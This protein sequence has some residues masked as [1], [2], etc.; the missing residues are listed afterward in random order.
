MCRKNGRPICIV[1]ASI[2]TLVAISSAQ[3]GGVWTPELCMKAKRVS[4]VQVSPDGAR[5]AFVVATAAMEGERSEWLSHIHL[6]RP[7][8]SAGFQLTQGDQS[9][10]SPR[11][12]SDGNWIAFISTRGGKPNLWRIRPDAGEA[13]QLTHEEGGVSGLEWSPDGT[14]IAFL[15]TDPA[16]EEERKAAKEKRDARVVDENIKLARLYVVPVEK[17]AGGGRPV[18][19]LTQGDYSVQG[20]FS[21]SPDGRSIVYSHQPTPVMND[22]PRA[23]ISIVDVAFAAERPFLTTNRAETSPHFSPDGRWIAYA[24]SDDPPSWGFTSRVYV[25]P[26]GG[27]QPKPLAESYD[28]Q[29]QL[30]GWSADGSRVFISETQKTIQR[31]SA[32]PV[33]AGAQIDI[34]PADLMVSGASISASRTHVGFT[35]DTPERAPEPYLSSLGGFA[36]RQ[37]DR[38]QDLTSP[39]IGKTEVIVWK[40]T[41]GKSVE[42]LLTY[43]AGHR[44]GSRVPLLVIVHGGPTGVFT[45]SFIASPGPYPIAVFAS[46]GYSVLRCNVRGS[47]GYGRDFRYANYQDWGGG[48]YRDIMSGV[49]HLI[50]QGLADPDR[51]GIMGWSYGG[52]MTSWVITQTKRFKAAS[53]GAGVTNLMSFS[54]TSDVPAFVPDYFGGE[55]WQVFDRWRSH[56]AMFN[57]GGAAT[58]TLIQH[59]EEDL[60]V[61]VT[62]GYELYNAIKRQNVPVKM[63]VYPR[64]PHGIQ[65]PKLQLDAMKRNLEWFDRWI[66]GN[67]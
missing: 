41:D 60:R 16:T 34:S 30:L 67:K 33:D 54:G 44:Q 6:S 24:A 3:H 7:D 49:D 47:S 31:F 9:C 66:G 4:D 23:D 13:E 27:G 59:G 14:R 40:S 28:S 45:R 35:S 11:W 32:L 8:G 19:K 29:P 10:R 12:S 62:Q 36:P 55:Y 56:S 65:E 48:D 61:P 17:D 15:M 51:L 57:V 63:V 18:R 20:G 58:P 46:R 38:V 42:G 26:A 21:W 5:A 2:L 39:P 22:W 43:P 37:V 52:Y 53:V 1:L 64:Q 25:I 50:Q